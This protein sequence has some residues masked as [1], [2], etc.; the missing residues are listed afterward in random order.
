MVTIGVSSL[1]VALLQ[2]AIGGAAYGF[3]T[4]A[5]NR[6]KQQTDKEQFDPRKLGATVILGA[7]IGITNALAGNPLTLETVSMTIAAHS[8]AVVLIENFLKWVGRWYKNRRG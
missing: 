4:Y 3:L 1:L 5:K 6:E 2:G 8:G 7:G